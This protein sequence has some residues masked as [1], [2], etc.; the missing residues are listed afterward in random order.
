MKRSVLFL[1]GLL[2]CAQQIYAQTYHYYKGVKYYDIGWYDLAFSEYVAGMN[3]GEPRSALMVAWCYLNESGT[4][5]N[6]KKAVSIL[7]Q[8]SLKDMTIC[9]FT[10][11]FYDESQCGMDIPWAADDIFNKKVPG[12][13]GPHDWQTGGIYTIYSCKPVFAVDYGLS[14]DADKAIKYAEILNKKVN[15]KTT[16]RF[17]KLLKLKKIEKSGDKIALLSALEPGFYDGY[18]YDRI[19]KE[20]FEQCNS[21]D[22]ISRVI[23]MDYSKNKVLKEATNSICNYHY[24]LL[25][26]ESYEMLS[27]KCLSFYRS[28]YEEFG[29]NQEALLDIYDK[30]PKIHRALN[31]GLSIAAFYKGW[32]KNN[33][34]ELEWMCENVQYDSVKEN[35]KS[36]WTRK[37]L[38]DYVINHKS[39]PE[40]DEL[41]ASSNYIEL[42]GNDPFLEEYFALYN[43]YLNT[44]KNYETTKAEADY[45][46]FL[47][48]KREL[49]LADKNIKN[50][51]WCEVSTHKT[52][53]YPIREQWFDAQ[54][55]LLANKENLEGIP[56]TQIF[57]ECANKGLSLDEN[58]L[59]KIVSVLNEDIEY[60]DSKLKDSDSYSVQRSSRQNQLEYAEFLLKEH[61]NSLSINDYIAF[62]R[63]N[64]DYG[65]YARVRLSVFKQYRLAKEKEIENRTMFSP[66]LIKQ[67]DAF[68]LLC[69]SGNR[70]KIKPENVS[71]LKSSILMP[72]LERCKAAY[73]IYPID[74][75]A[76]IQ[77]KY[78]EEIAVADIIL[79]YANDNDAWELSKAFLKQYPSSAYTQLITDYCNDSYAIREANMLNNQSSKDD[80]KKVLSLPM[81]KSGNKQ[82]K[83]L[84]KNLNLKNK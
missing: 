69:Q 67:H 21:L 4:P 81:T 1:F 48:A 35:A 14:D 18:K 65:N 59:G 30:N 31:D 29:G 79:K 24:S 40:F 12:V 38:K 33:I 68:I 52:D 43:E 6:V 62:Q 42:D 37:Y 57:A 76:D 73:N 84:I 13:D 32:E 70:T 72:A 28:L 60:M 3:A 78:D 11:I 44:K 10:A 64:A 53:F 58:K 55:S 49:D 26:K 41:F 23:D 2:F 22:D 7:E 5:R 45:Y 80:I 54:Y 36:V 50:N 74:G 15:T 83:A 61:D 34:E 17:V 20:A 47:K 82:V 66:K 56:Y 8:W 27:N 19:L 39:W 71:N 9:L 75:I 46:N 77:R 25:Y 51:N 63:D 16:S